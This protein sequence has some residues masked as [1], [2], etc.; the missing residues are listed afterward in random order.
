M[1]WEI[2][3]MW[4]IGLIG[5]LFATAIILKEVA[6]VLRE[7]KGI[8]RLAEAIREAAAGVEANL[9]AIAKL[10][11]LEEPVRGFYESTRSLSAATT[12]VGQKLDT[13]AAGAGEQGG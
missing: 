1:R 12:S 6:L 7:L 8:Q 3:V 11:Q 4:S 2:R 13:L 10:A 9:S 5:A